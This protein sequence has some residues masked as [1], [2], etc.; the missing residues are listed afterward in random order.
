MQKTYL[1]APSD[2]VAES[3]IQKQ[4]LRPNEVRRVRDVGDIA[5]LEPG[6][7]ILILRGDSRTRFQYTHQA[8]WMIIELQSRYSGRCRFAFIDML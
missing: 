2:T 3:Y 5:G 7:T 1:I 6:Q 8:Y 4:Q